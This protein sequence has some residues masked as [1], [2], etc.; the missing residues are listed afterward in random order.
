MIAEIIIDELVVETI[1]GCLPHERTT[2]QPLTI[3]LAIQYDISHVAKTDNID[4]AMNYADLAEEIKLY[5]QN[6][7]FQLLEGLADKIF[8]IVFKRTQVKQASLLIYKPNAIK[9]IKRVGIKLSR[10][11]EAVV[12]SETKTSTL[13]WD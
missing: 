6:S 12:F 2:K 4:D 11:N 1:I 9:G 8:N 7:Q 10:V 5:V 13:S 3:S